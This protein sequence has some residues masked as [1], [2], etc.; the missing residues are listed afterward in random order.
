M[1]AADDAVDQA[2][3][4]AR[5]SGAVAVDLVV[6]LLIAVDATKH[7]AVIESIDLIDLHCLNWSMNTMN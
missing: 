2:A 4:F 3:D 1:A 6:V 7:F 5:Y